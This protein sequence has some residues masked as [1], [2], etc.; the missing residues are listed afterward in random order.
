MGALGRIRLAIG[1]FLGW[2]FLVGRCL[3]TCLN[4]KGV[5]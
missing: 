1:Q 4:K 3:W 5:W 2:Q